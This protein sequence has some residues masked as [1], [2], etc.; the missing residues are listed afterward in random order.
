MKRI[1]AIV[2]L[3][4]LVAALVNPTANA[5]NAFNRKDMV[6]S[7]GIGLGL[8]G[9]YGTSTLPPIFVAFETGVADKITAGGIVAYAGSSEDFFYGKWSYNYI[10]ISARG[11][12][13]FLENNKNI[14]AYAG[15][16]L[17]Y[18][19]V[20]SSVTWNDPTYQQFAGRYSASGSMFFFDVF[21]GGRYYFSPKFAAQAEVGYGVGFLRIGLAYKLN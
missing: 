7:A 4:V 15:A 8:Y 1:L 16:G 12:Y 3:A 2:V 9:L 11:A 5:Q 20:S 19:I 17:G 21:L 10:V 6:L 14:D 18:D 13:H